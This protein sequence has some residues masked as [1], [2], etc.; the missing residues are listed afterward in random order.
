MKVLL[1]GAAGR[2]G[3]E[4]CRHF[5]SEGIDFR[6]TDRR[7]DPGL[8]CEITVADARNREACYSLVEGCD[9]VVHLANYPNANAGDA[10]TVYN[11]NCAMNM[12]VFQAAF[13]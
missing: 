6:A 8:P 10:Q 2:M 12:N 13:E 4:T 9:A 5:K 7:T 1:T 11:E 3:S